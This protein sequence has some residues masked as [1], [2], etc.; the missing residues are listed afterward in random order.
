MSE[1]EAVLDASAFLAYLQAET[2][3][4]AVQEALSRGCTMSAVNWAEVLS[5]V[6]DLGKPGHELVAE[7]QDR[8]L[9]GTSLR[10]IPFDEHDAPVVGDLRPQTR[11]L[12]LSLGDRAC[13]ALGQRLGSPILTTDRSWEKLDSELEIRLIR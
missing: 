9:L 6:A 7:L 1:S 3:A 12:G 11:H 13:L 10:I 8:R 4:D 5:K 2:G